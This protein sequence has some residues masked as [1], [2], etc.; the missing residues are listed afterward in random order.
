MVN[1]GHALKCVY[2][3]QQDLSYII[4]QIDYMGDV[5]NHDV[6]QLYNDCQIING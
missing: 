1:N 4:L 5:V 6:F 3:D 2:M